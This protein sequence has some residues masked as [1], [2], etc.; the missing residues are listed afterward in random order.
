M[1]ARIK[2]ATVDEVQKGS[3]AEASAARQTL[4]GGNGGGCKTTIVRVSLNSITGRRKDA[5]E[6]TTIIII[7]LKRGITS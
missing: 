3:S 5:S 7:T 6:K 2:G 4:R 1:L